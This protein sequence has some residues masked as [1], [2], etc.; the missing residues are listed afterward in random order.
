LEEAIIDH[1]DEGIQREVDEKNL[2]NY[3]FNNLIYPRLLNLYKEFYKVT[4]QNANYGFI[5]RPSFREFVKK[6]NL[7]INKR[8]N[9][10]Y[11]IKKINTQKEIEKYL[12]HELKTTKFTPNKI[13]KMEEIEGLVISAD[14]VLRKVKEYGINSRNVLRDCKFK[15]LNKETAVEI[16]KPIIGKV[17]EKINR[18]RIAL[19]IPLFRLNEAP[20]TRQL[21]QYGY[22]DLLGA[23]ERRK[24]SY[25]NDI[26]KKL[27]YKVNRGKYDQLNLNKTNASEIF[28]LVIKEVKE[29]INKERK[30]RNEPLLRP[31]EAPTKKELKEYGYGGLVGAV[32]RR[33]ISYN[34]DIL[35]KLGYEIK[36]DI[37]KFKDLNSD[38]ILKF[39]K[40]IIEKVRAKI[41]EERKTRN[42]PPL[43]PNEAPTI[44]QLKQHGYRSLIEAAERRKIS[45]NKDILEQL[46][47]EFN[48]APEKYK[49]LD[50]RNAG[51]FLDPI[52]KD[53]KEKLKKFEGIILG[54]EQVP[55]EE[56]FAKYNY[57]GLITALHTRG[58]S[59]SEVE[60]ELGYV[61]NNFDI[62]IEIGKNCHRVVERIC[63]EYTRDLGCDTFRQARTNA[64][65]NVKA[66]DFTI[67]RNETFKLK[68]ES[69]QELIEIPS[70]IE[71]INVD[72]FIG[73]SKEK[74]II[75]SYR[76]YQGNKKIL[77]LVPFGA[78]KNLHQDIPKNAG[79]YFPEN[80]KIMNPHEFAD[81]LGFKG[82]V[83]DYFN[84]VVK[85][86]NRAIYDSNATK[87]LSELA[88]K[89]KN[90]LENEYNFGHE[91]FEQ[92]VQKI[93]KTYLLFNDIPKTSKQ[94]T[95]DATFIN[96]PIMRKIDKIKNYINQLVDFLNFS[97]VVKKTAIKLVENAID[98]DFSINRKN[99]EGIAAGAVYLSSRF[100]NK[101]I[102]GIKLA[103]K[104]NN[105]S[106]ITI[107]RR[108]KDLLA[109]MEPIQLEKLSKIL[110]LFKDH[111]LE[112]AL[113]IC[114][115]TNY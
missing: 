107:Y 89:E 29:R 108:A 28:S 4:G 63:I 110:Q 57:G 83:L 103:D 100:F 61:S 91:K 114:S 92:Y 40:P 68:I 11:K 79:I 113:I 30:T 74:A 85:L 34:D 115:L 111:S 88:I 52:I 6:Q 23:A 9:I 32:E 17:R 76:G 82:K 86:V 60:E 97:H 22:K 48:Y 105:F 33:K 49:N 15:Y 112:L 69:K 99:L 27:G 2:L 59:V 54:K 13:A 64:R 16:F 3:S 38:T 53:V 55:T 7:D 12:I 66:P 25:N 67:M 75:K 80:V 47:Y 26:L 62:I 31:N 81:F 72:F 95:L 71:I 73:N 50:R 77:I 93:G 14:A 102:S 1:S 44:R 109:K 20:T 65:D 98:R 94:I 101:S 19:N 24:I 56:Q 37:N 18:E 42:E 45:Y 51:E 8:E 46:E 41:N 78:P 5:L 39:F 10:L 96:K 70:E 87:E 90:L 35:K 104:I 36:V 21:I 84:H 106:E 58:I 43:R